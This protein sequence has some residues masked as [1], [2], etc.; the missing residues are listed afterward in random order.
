MKILLCMILLLF[1]SNCIYSQYKIQASVM[2][3]GG[4]VVSNSDFNI[5]STIGQTLIG[6]L[7]ANYD[8]QVGFWKPAQILTPIQEAKNTLPKEYKLEQNYPNPF[9]PST[10]ISY[11]VP[12]ESYVTLKVYDI[13]GREVAALVSGEKPTGQYKVN[14]NAVN[15]ASGIYFYRIDAKSKTFSKEFT[16]VGKMILLK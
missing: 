5:S 9:N 12:Q 11:E 4:V 3:N 7:Q 10:T 6:R 16:K 13:L 8:L 14:F 2:A 15:L 1:F